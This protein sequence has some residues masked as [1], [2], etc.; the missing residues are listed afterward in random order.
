MHISAV[1][2][3]LPAAAEPGLS[4]PARVRDGEGGMRIEVWPDELRCAA[5]ELGRVI[6]EVERLGIARQLESAAAAVPGGRLAASAAAAADRWRRD[7]A[8]VV[9][10]LAERASSLAQA[11]AAYAVAESRA[12]GVPAPPGAAAPSAGGEA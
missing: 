10:E 5:A 9:A 2:P 6:A 12:A 1:A 7:R 11:A 8:R 3:D 4:Q